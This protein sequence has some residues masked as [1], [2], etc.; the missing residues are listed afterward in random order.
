MYS[1]ID[2]INWRPFYKSK[3]FPIN[4]HSQTLLK[5][6]L[7]CEKDL[8]ISKNQLNSKIKHEIYELHSSYMNI[9]YN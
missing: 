3:H 1:I 7:S 5:D 4:N 8:L 9:Y 2:D 6:T